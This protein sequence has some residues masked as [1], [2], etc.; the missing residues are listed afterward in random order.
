MTFTVKEMINWL[1][2]FDEDMEVLLGEEQRYGCDFAYNIR[3][4]NERPFTE[5]DNFG[6]PV[7][8]DE[9][10]KAVVITLDRQIGTIDYDNEDDGY[11]Y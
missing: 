11:Y 8:R 10:K 7:R 1:K 2:D 5:W 9:D 4:I 3:D 6:T